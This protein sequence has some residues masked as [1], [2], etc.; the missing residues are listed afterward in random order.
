MFIEWYRYKSTTTTITTTALQ[1]TALPYYYRLPV[2][3]CRPQG[4]RF[5]NHDSNRTAATTNP[6]H[7]PFLLVPSG[8]V[9]VCSLISIS[10]C[11]IVIAIRRY[12]PS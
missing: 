1:L 12:R 10:T 3:S 7:Y 11:V 8:V 2:L 6:M 4:I 9:F 5:I